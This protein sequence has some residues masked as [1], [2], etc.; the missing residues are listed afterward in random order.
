MLFLCVEEKAFLF[1]MTLYPYFIMHSK[2]E[3]PYNFP[4]AVLPL[5][6]GNDSYMALVSSS[7]KVTGGHFVTF[8]SPPII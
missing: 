6:C 8:S 5:C 7:I 2:L 1:S 3:I 4:Q